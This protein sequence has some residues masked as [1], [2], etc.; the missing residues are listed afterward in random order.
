MNPQI[1]QQWCAALREN[2]GMFYESSLRGGSTFSPDGLL[3][4]IYLKAHGLEWEEINGKYCALGRSHAMPDE[5]CKWAGLTEIIKRRTS[6]I[7]EGKRV[8]GDFVEYEANIFDP[9]LPSFAQFNTSKKGNSQPVLSAIAQD[10]RNY[11]TLA[12]I[13]EKDL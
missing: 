11:A 3:V 13:I 6:K 4:D 8:L 5:V 12:D 1:K 2:D 10:C 7:I 9:I